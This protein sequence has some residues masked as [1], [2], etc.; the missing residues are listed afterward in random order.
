[1]NVYPAAGLLYYAAAD[2]PIYLIDPNEVSLDR[3][4]VQII[5]KGAS[6]GVRELVR[7]LTE[8]D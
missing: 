3:K 6:E 7:C 8:T 2:V 5:K 1:L 4:N